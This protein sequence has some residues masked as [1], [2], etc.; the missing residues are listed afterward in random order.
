MDEVSKRI[1]TV[2][3]NLASTSKKTSDVVSEMYVNDVWSWDTSVSIVS[4]YSLDNQGSISD[5]GKQFFL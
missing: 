2:F 1:Y 3:K 4:D 5:R